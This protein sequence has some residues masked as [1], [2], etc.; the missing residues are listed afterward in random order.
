MEGLDPGKSPQLPLPVLA[1]LSLVFL[2]V[3]GLTLRRAG[4]LQGM[5][6]VA[7]I[8]LRVIFGAFQ[9]ITTP[10]V[11]GGLSL[12]ALLSVTTIG[13]GI[14]VVSR[15]AFSQVWMIPFYA[16][17]T[18]MTISAGVNGV[19][20]G[21]IDMGFKWAFVIIFIAA[22]RDAMIQA[23]PNRILQLIFYCY[24]PV[25]VFQGLSVVLRLGKDTEGAD[26]VSYIG[27]YLHEAPFSML[28]LTVI[29][30]LY[31][32]SKLPLPMKLLGILVGLVSI[33]LANYRTAIIAALPLL[34]G[35][36]AFDVAPRFETRSRIAANILLVAGG[37]MI[38]VLGVDLLAARF[39]DLGTVLLDIGHFVKPPSA[40]PDADQKILSGRPFIWA[41]YI[42]RY[43]NGGDLQ[44]LFGF[45]PNSWVGIFPRYAHNTVV[46]F[47]YELG[48]FGT[49]SLLA[50]W[51]TFIVGTLNVVDRQIR[52]KILLAQ[53]GF[54]LLNMATMPH[55][56]IEGDIFFAILQGFLLYHL[57]GAPR[58]R[59][60]LEP[61]AAGEA[62]ATIRGR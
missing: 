45:G 23:G 34:A 42:Y 53:I 24:I 61:R 47:I 14:F 62:E 58:R 54:F 60:A 41:G 27:G 19:V 6:L 3:L 51:A 18:A 4:S 22:T 25:I 17:L 9:N 1:A 29:L 50:I 12:N 21:L 39:A 11:I 40:Y 44:L 20:G 8:W 5:F 30:V 48:V 26:A 33:L 52:S 49:A 57:S 10:P 59:T 35:V 15:R 55:Y 43:I 56:N 36:L 13:I 16:L 37:L 38:M 2:V 31:L 28:A 46:S 32:Q 7:A